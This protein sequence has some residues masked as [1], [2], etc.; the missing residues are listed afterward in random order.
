MERNIHTEE[1]DNRRF[2]VKPNQWV[3]SPLQIP[4]VFQQQPHRVECVSTSAAQKF[5]CPLAEQP[6]GDEE[7]NW[8][9]EKSSFPQK[10]IFIC[11][12]IR[13][14]QEILHSL[15]SPKIVP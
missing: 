11:L 9:L 14:M 4:Q 1:L 7:R 3:Q 8:D 10:K 12:N 5:F 6:L 2:L 13:L 15:C